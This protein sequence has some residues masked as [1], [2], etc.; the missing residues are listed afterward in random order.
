V[1]K[2]QMKYGLP[3]DSYP[4]VELLAKFGVQA[5]SAEPG[6]SGQPMAPVT[7]KR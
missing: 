7:R 2:A 3:A 6:A 5:T 4:T 1:K